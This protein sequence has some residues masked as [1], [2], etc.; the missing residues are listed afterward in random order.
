[1]KDGSMFMPTYS[2]VALIQREEDR[3]E[4]FN[5]DDIAIE[6]SLMK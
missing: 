1:M 2:L 5:F 6:T 3:Y 4:E